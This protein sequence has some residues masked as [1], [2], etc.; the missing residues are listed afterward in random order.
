MSNIHFGKNIKC[1]H[2]YY[3]VIARNALKAHTDAFVG[4]AR[5]KMLNYNLYIFLKP[6]DALFVCVV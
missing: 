1:E 3:K 5:I 2:W 6:V 4:L